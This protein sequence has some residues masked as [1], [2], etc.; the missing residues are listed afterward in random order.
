M[1]FGELAGRI[2]L[3]ALALAVVFAVFMGFTKWATGRDIGA[4]KLELL[5]GVVNT[6]FLL[7]LAMGILFG[8]WELLTS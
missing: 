5:K 6:I 2:M 3:G 4:E 8:I 7:G 1:D